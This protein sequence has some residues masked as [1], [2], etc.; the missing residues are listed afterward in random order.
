MVLACVIVAVILFG[1]HSAMLLATR[2][3]PDRSGRNYASVQG[4][5]AID[6]LSADLSMATAMTSMT[7]TSIEFTVPDRNGDNTPETINYSWSGSPGDPLTCTVNGGTPANVALNVNEFALTYDKRSQQ[8]STTYTES[9]EIVLAAYDGLGLLN[10]GDFAVDSSDFVGQYFLPTLPA[11]AA[12]WRVTRVK[13]LARQHSGTTGEARVQLRTFSSPTPQLILEEKIMSESSL[14]TS[15]QWQEFAFSGV[16]GRP[17]G[18]PLCLVIQWNKD[19]QACD[20]QYQ[21]LGGLAANAGLVKTSNGGSSWSI[22]LAQDMPFYI[23]GTY[24]TQDPVAYDYWLTGVRCSLRCGNDTTS[25]VR[26]SMRL[27][28]Q[29]QVNGP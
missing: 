23:Y 19:T 8:R 26:T 11:Q 20:V 13:F 2:A 3:N 16:S 14:P 12:S 15:Y 22:P 9:G 7:P 29:P 5:M 24:S 17:P 28:N 27:L 6:R 10:L 21:L 25:R 18:T 4:G 1:M